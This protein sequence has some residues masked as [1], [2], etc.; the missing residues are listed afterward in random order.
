MIRKI[1][2]KITA[3]ILANLLLLPIAKEVYGSDYLRIAYL[4]ANPPTISQGD[5]STIITLLNSHLEW[6]GEEG[7]V[8]VTG[9]PVVTINIVERDLNSAC[10]YSY[11]GPIG[12]KRE[13]R[14][15]WE[16]D[17]FEGW[18]HSWQWVFLYYYQDN[19]Y[20]FEALWDGRDTENNLVGIGEYPFTAIAQILPFSFM[21]D[22]KEGKITVTAPAITI[23]D[24]NWDSL[25]WDT[26]LK[27][28][29]TLYLQVSKGEGN[30]SL[31]E[32]IVVTVKSN[33]T[34]PV[35]IQL[36]LTETTPTSNIY[37]G[38]TLI[39]PSL[40]AKG[41]DG[42]DEFADADITTPNDSNA[43]S[44]GMS[45]KKDMGEARKEGD[46]KKMIPPVNIA[47]MQAAGIE[48][49]TAIYGDTS[50]TAFCKNQADWFYYSGHGFHTYEGITMGDGGLFTPDEATNQW[51]NDLYTVIF[52]ACSM[53]DVNDY[54]GYFD[55]NEDGTPEVGPTSK[56]FPGEKWANTGP[57]YLL[58]YNAS[59]P[60][61]PYTDTAII[62]KWLKYFSIKGIAQSWLKV[63]ADYMA[64]YAS[65]ID[66]KGYWYLVPVYDPKER[67]LTYEARGPIPRS[68]W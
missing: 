60:A 41:E 46:E 56:V 66:A 29:E 44:A 55:D 10:T 24:S 54:L 65:A 12:M 62:N 30:P 3:L 8:H 58:G 20:R 37:R 53:I 15:V 5:S 14:L 39:T 16:Y 33:L 2:Y 34:N 63:N 48:K 17:P 26:V 42:V 67:K 50:D 43:F 19:S 4:S 40:I 32:T 22:S 51:N 45:P 49:L 68:E 6:G 61:G 47:F 35:G 27:V 11:L 57:K 1:N 21:M 38:S 52:A 13:W 64:A 28:G 31:Q 59:A 7:G 25:S 9:T 36:T 18:I 23:C